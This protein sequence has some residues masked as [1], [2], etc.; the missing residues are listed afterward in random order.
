MPVTIRRALF[1][2]MILATPT[3]ILKAQE[4]ATVAEA[5]KVIDLRT[6]PLMPGGDAKPPR[7][8]ASFGYTARSDTREAYAFQKKTLEE[9]GWKEFPGGYMSDQSCSGAFGKDGY[10]V[11]VTTSPSYGPK[12]AGMVDIR[13]VN[14]GNVDVSKLPVAPDAKPLYSF[15]TVTAYVTEIPVKETS[16]ALRTLLMAKG[17][18]PYGHAGDALYFKKS[19]VKLTAWP[20]AAPAQGGKTVIQLSTELMSVDLPAPPVLLEA[21]Y[22]DTTTALSLEVDMKPEALAAFYKEALGK[23]G[24]KATTENPVKIHFELMMIFRNDAKDIMTLKMHNFEGKL[25]AIIEHQTAAEFAEVMRLAQAEEAKRKADSAAYA[26]K[27]AEAAASDRVTVSITI[28]AGAKAVKRDKS[29][30]E[31][32]LAPGKAKAAVQAIHAALVKDGWKGKTP[33]FEPM[34]GTVSLDKKPG[35]TLVIVYVDTGLGDAEVTISSFGSDIE[36]PKA[37]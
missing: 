13:L 33:R 12:A 9:R 11:S 5:A 6:L 21:A 14:H 4:P 37:K 36:E 7:R 25:R 16:E 18:E 24:W 15:P 32:K 22:A 23:A 28:P 30:L 2:V 17:W 29:Q 8:L 31:F 1:A 26:K 20:S 3:G 35:V 19:A 34:A 10:T 27:A